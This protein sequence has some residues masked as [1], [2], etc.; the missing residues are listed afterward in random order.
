MEYGDINSVFVFV[1]HRIDGLNVPIGYTQ[2]Q[3]LKNMSVGLKIV[4]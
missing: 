1:Y 2:M 4:N 3:H